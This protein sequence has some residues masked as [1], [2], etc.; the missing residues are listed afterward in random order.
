[1][2]ATSSYPFL[3]FLLQFRVYFVRAGGSSILCGLSCKYRT[4]SGTGQISDGWDRAG[5][6]PRLPSPV[7]V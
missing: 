1:M 4:L 6:S 3:K 2:C 7:S 5:R